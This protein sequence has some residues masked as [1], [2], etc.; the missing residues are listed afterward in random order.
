LAVSARY[1]QWYLARDRYR[2]VWLQGVY[3]HRLASRVL[4]RLDED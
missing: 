3:A 1:W 2:L 4:D